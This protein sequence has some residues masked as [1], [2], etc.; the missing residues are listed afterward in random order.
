MNII[1]VDFRHF[2]PTW[3]MERK[4]KKGDKNSWKRRLHLGRVIIDVK[5]N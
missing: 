3:M 5:V 4:K 2:N 1:Q